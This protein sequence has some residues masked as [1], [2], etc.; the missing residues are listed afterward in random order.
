MDGLCRKLH[1]K[2][3]LKLMNYLSID[4]LFLT[5]LSFFEI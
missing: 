1:I 2:D 5:S 3:A 4:E